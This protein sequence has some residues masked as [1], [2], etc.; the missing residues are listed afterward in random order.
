[1]PFPDGTAAEK[2]MAHQFKEPT[3]IREL[4]PDVP[5]GLAEVVERLMK[6]AP[7]ARYASAAEVVEALRP[8]A[9]SAPTA[10][11]PAARPQPAR[12]AGP[13]PKSAP[14]L[15]E[16]PRTAPEAPARAA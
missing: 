8:L 10:P 16:S 9:Q 14:A 13:A 6:K 7:E 3:P 11:K 15:A 1:F 2:M 4:S 5:A 12:D